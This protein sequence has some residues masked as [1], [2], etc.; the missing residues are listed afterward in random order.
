LKNCV[1]NLNNNMKEFFYILGI[2]IGI[3]LFIM[4]FRKHF[5]SIEIQNEI[6]IQKVDSLYQLTNEL[7]SN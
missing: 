1:T 5:N 3:Y 6:I 7:K 4:P 2:I